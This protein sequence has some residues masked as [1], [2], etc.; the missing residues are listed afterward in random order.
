MDLPS[1]CGSPF[2][3]R[4]GRRDRPPACNRN[5]RWRAGASMDG[6]RIERVGRMS[7]R[8]EPPCRG[9]DAR[10]HGLSGKRDPAGVAPAPDVT[11]PAVGAV[12]AERNAALADA[13]ARAIRYELNQLKARTAWL[14]L[15][16]RCPA[17][18]WAQVRWQGLR[19]D[20]ARAGR[21]SPPL[22]SNGHSSR[23][24]T[25]RS[26]KMGPSLRYLIHSPE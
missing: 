14:R 15:L 9:V 22:L 6:C 4:C 18:V 12:T 26:Q 5:R 3:G 24:G 11:I 21:R 16:L 8:E 10:L 17:F 1:R 23:R 13:E 2:R 19:V 20:L 7:G 25:R